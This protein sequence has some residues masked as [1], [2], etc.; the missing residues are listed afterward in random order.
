[1]VLCSF[2]GSGLVGLIGFAGLGLTGFR[3]H[4]LGRLSALGV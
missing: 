2:E 4:I 3:V 1:M